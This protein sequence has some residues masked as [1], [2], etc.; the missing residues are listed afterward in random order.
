VINMEI[1]IN[2]KEENLIELKF[3]HW[4][5]SFFLRKYLMR[6]LLF[7]SFQISSFSFSSADATI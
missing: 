7:L 3:L 6:L 5:L 1:V 2:R 4:Y